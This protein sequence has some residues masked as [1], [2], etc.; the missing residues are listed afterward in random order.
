MKELVGNHFL[1]FLKI[2][3]PPQVLSSLL[4]LEK[5]NISIPFLLLKYLRT[6]A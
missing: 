5:W 3:V 1:E 2:L 4:Y 6:I